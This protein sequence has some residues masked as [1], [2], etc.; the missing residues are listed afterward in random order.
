MDDL[1]KKKP[2]PGGGSAV[3]LASCLGISLIEK[4]ISFSIS[5]DESLRKYLGSLGELKKKV[6]SY[7]DQDGQIFEQILKAKGSSKLELI[8][9]SEEIIITTA[10]ACQEVFCLAGIIKSG[11]KKSIISD[12]YIG[13]EF[14]AAALK[15]CVF[16]LEANR[17]IFGKKSRYIKIFKRYLTGVS[18]K[19]SDK[20]TPVNSK[21]KIQ[22]AK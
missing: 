2:S 8:G 10:K 21:C 15:G 3:C 9:K 19:F 16:N 7:I 13:L 18:T 22:N 4:A 1:A 11:I 6:Y 14:I 12:F 17:G 5:K 20:E